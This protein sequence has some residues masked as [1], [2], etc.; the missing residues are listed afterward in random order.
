MH[1]ISQYSQRSI[2]KDSIS[3]GFA[4]WTQPTMK[5]KQLGEKFQKVPKGKTSICCISTTI[6]YMAVI[7]YWAFL[8]AQ[9]VKNPPTMLET[10][11]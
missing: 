10:W 11:V 9:M 4:L 6:Y 2:S 5:R 8:V 3:T 7:L 1:L